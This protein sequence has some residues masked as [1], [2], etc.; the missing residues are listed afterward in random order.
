[1]VRLVEGVDAHH[2][3]SYSGR[4]L[5]GKE[6]GKDFVEIGNLDVDDRMAGG[7]ESGDFGVLTL[8]SRSR[9]ADVGE[10]AIVAV[11]LRRGNSFAIHGRNAL[12]QLASRF[13][14]QL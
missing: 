10:D 1:H 2:R 13:G 3:T 12:A 11:D 8:V 9:V 6:L 14:N 4:H 7:L 5:P